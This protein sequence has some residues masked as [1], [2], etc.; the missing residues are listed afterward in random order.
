M[1]P[2]FVAMAGSAPLALRATTS[3]LVQIAAQ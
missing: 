1:L 2:Q 3:T